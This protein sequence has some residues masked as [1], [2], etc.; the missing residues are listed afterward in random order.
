MAWIADTEEWKALTAHCEEVKKTHLR[1]L[2]RDDARTDAMIREYNGIYFDFSR[3]NATQDTLKLL[4]DLAKRA[5]VP[6]KIDAMFRGDHINATEDRAVLHVALRA[7]R[8]AVINDNGVNMVPEVWA[9][10]DKIKSF[11]EKVR[12]GGWLGVT[13]KPLTNVVAIGIGGSYLGPAF[14][15]T[16]LEMEPTAM[17]AAKGRSLTFLANVDPVD[18]VASLST[19]NPE[20]TLAI[21]VSKTFTTAETMRNARTVRAW[22]TSALG[23]EAIARHMIAVSTN[24]KAATEFG[25][26]ADNMF[27]F[28]DWVGGRFS[29]S[30]AVG[31]LPLSLQYGFVIVEQFLKGLH[32]IDMHFASR[33]LETNLPVLQ[34]LLNVWNSTFLGHSTCA[35]L[36]YSQALSKFAPHIQQLSMES[37]G[38]GVDMEG[39][40]LPY[41]AGE[42]DFGEPGT[43]GQHSFYQLVH[44]G[45]VVPAEFIGL[46]ASQQDIYLNGEPVSSHEELMCNFFAQ[47][48]ALAVG[49]G[50]EDLKAQ[51]VAPNLVPHKTFQ[52]NRPSLTIL[53][54]ELTAYTLGQLLAL[55]EHRIA[56]SGFVWGINSFDQWGV[57]LGKVLANKVRATITAARKNG[58]QLTE[59]HGKELNS[60]SRRLISKFLAFEVPAPSTVGGQDKVPP[61]FF[62]SR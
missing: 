51:G 6:E 34:G 31:V 14:V 37:N 49:L 23:K 27:G 18:A 3:Q 43:N 30:S 46:I 55:Y 32:D 22:L 24:V 9:V 36:P 25:I 44:Q 21:I 52:G 56:V 58:G 19:L 47:P 13:G 62:K 45:R 33:P 10:L 48:D 20:T 1:D 41:S 11:S 5:K 42:I 54:P 35:I 16:A 17:E 57:E 2:L 7:P 39:N 15:H 26:D 28:W 4:L 50:P 8:D 29:V 60:S 61:G 59:S 40:V 12:S 38:K 53:L